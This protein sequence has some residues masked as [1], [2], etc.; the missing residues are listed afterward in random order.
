[1]AK[2]GIEKEIT[3]HIKGFMGLENTPPHRRRWE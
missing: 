3:E 2:Y 1:M